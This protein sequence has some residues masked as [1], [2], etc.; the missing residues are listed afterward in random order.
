[1]RL[2]LIPP[3]QIRRQSILREAEAS[4]LAR[5]EHELVLLVK[6]SLK[7]ELF[8]SAALPLLVNVRHTLRVHGFV[9]SV[10]LVVNEVR[11]QLFLLVIRNIWQHGLGLLAG[12]GLR[13]FYVCVY[14]VLVEG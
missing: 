3:L 6:V 1:M 4:R 10:E 13:H 9:L 7:L 11:L 14:V 8:R 12:R 5:R 2:Q